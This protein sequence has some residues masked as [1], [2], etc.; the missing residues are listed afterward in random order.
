MLRRSWGIPMWVKERERSIGLSGR[1]TDPC[2]GCLA[3]NW[4]I[5]SKGHTPACDAEVRGNIAAS[6]F[7]D[8]PV[9]RGL[10]HENTNKCRYTEPKW[11]DVDS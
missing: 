8:H 10:G 3:C 2:F 1:I 9:A 4:L 11:S 5:N 6:R 7:R